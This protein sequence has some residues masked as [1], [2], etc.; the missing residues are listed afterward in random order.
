MKIERICQYCNSVFVAQKTTTKYCSL[1][2]GSRAYKSNVKALRI[3]LSNKE[4]Q[5]IKNS[6]LNT[7]EFLSVVD[8]ARLLGVS[9]RVIYA[10]IS[11]G[12]LITNNLNQRLT[13][14]RRAEIDKLFTGN[15]GIN[16]DTTKNNSDQEIIP[17]FSKLTESSY[18]S[19]Q[20]VREK[21][22]VSE[23][24]LRQLIIK[25]EI[26]KYRRGWFAYVPKSV[27][28]KLFKP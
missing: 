24:A 2:C 12:E 22:G 10:M 17:P 8:A 15:V 23:S 18:Y 4:T 27:I 20:E 28:D 1:K 16:S 6:D 5:A 19:T 3:E 13:R 21:Y 9:R 14:I 11:R 25:H 7:K 26:P